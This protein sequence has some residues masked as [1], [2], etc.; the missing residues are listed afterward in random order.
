MNV[1][2]YA[3]LTALRDQAK[4]LEMEKTAA[5]LEALIKEQRAEK[6]RK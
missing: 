1:E 3:K 2:E 4:R 5:A 6:R